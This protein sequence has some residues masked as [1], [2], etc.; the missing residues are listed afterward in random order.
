MFW[1][2]SRAF[3]LFHQ[4]AFL[5][6]PLQLQVWQLPLQHFLHSP[7]YN[8]AK[9][10]LHTEAQSL[11]WS[12]RQKTISPRNVLLKQMQVKLAYFYV[13]LLAKIYNNSPAKVS[14][15]IFYLWYQNK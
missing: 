7:Y 5:Q 6:S 9:P 8:E 4:P 10:P 3:A 1:T 2:S 15:L 13:G 14:V 11:C 12:K